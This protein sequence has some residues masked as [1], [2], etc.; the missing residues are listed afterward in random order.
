MIREILIYPNKRLKVVSK[1]VTSFD[2]K[3]HT[4][5]D[6]MYETMVA[7]NGVG[8]AGIQIGIEL[9]VLI[10]NIPIGD[11][12]NALQPKENTLEV[13]NPIFLEKNGTRIYQEGCL[14]IPTVFEEV[15]RAKHIKLEYQD[16]FGKK[17]IIEDN[18]FL[19]IALQHEIEHLEGHLFIENLS[20]SKRKKFEKEWKKL[21]NKR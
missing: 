11:D 20:F 18:E 5:L 19:S 15:K 12:D 4:L 9:R 1:D 3:L 21:G 14:S 17:Q 6:D 13:I 8:L 16:R 10:V 2:A 7:K